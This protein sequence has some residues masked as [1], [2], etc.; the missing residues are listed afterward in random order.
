MMTSQLYE[1]FKQG[2][3]PIELIINYKF[4]PEIVGKEYDRFLKLRQL[5]CK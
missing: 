2:I 5:N 1:L 3:N 4:A